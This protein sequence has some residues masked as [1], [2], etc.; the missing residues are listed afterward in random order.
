MYLGK[1]M[2]LANRDELYSAPMHPYTHALM[3]AVP[4]PDPRRRGAASASPQG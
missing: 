1:I 2:E 3:S 4:V